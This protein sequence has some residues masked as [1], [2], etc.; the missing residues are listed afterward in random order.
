MGQAAH[1]AIEQHL[2]TRGWRSWGLRKPF[3]GQLV[4]AFGR[5]HAKWLAPVAEWLLPVQ[6]SWVPPAHLLGVVFWDTHPDLHSPPDPLTAC[7]H[8]VGFAL[9]LTKYQ[10]FGW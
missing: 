4:T 7:V 2:H 3:Q 1:Q 6:H 5:K 9:S 10:A 8:S